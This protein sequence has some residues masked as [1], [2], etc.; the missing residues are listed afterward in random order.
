M[1]SLS[2]LLISDIPLYA[3]VA[4]FI[5]WGLIERSFRFRNQQQKEGD[6]QDR[7]TYW[8]TSLFW[9][10]VMVYSIFD[11]FW[12]G[13]TVLPPGW[14]ALQW[15]GIPI[16]LLGLYVRIQARQALGTQHS[17]KVQ[18]SEAH[19]LVTSGIYRTI[20]HPAYLGF[21]CLM[22]GAPLCLGSMAGLALAIVGGIPAIIYRIQIEEQA[23]SSWFGDDYIEYTRQTKRLIPGLW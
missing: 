22:V 12:L 23:L 15:V 14:R 7:G 8:L 1:P 11:A 19:Q 20:R 17:A 10:A 4:G 6:S 3:G 13:W 9:F 18:T 5:A 2:T 16:V 21:I